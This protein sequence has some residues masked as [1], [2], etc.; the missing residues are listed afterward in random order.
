[1]AAA[2]ARVASDKILF[3]PRPQ[4]AE[5]AAPEFFHQL[6]APLFAAPAVAVGR[7]CQPLTVL[8]REH[9]A[10]EVAIGMPPVDYLAQH[11][12][13]KTLAAAEG[14][15]RRKAPQTPRV[16]AAALA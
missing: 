2:A 13:S 6:R 16:E 9:V 3:Q 11:P 12:D 8:G 4:K 14:G 15:Q 10:E 7:F 1:V 5:T